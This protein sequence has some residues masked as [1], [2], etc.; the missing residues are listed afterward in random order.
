MGSFQ[1]ILMFHFRSKRTAGSF[2]QKLLP[3]SQKATLHNACAVTS[4]QK[5]QS[6][7]LLELLCRPLSLEK[8]HTS[9]ISKHS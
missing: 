7:L 3:N 9:A 1:V 5:T 8:D 2:L 6:H 4:P